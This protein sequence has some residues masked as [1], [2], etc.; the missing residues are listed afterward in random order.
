VARCHML[1]TVNKN[2]RLGSQLSRY[3]TLML[4]KSFS[5]TRASDNTH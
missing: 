5:H 2:L 4:D 1:T 3:H